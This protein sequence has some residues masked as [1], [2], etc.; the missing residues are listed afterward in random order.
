MTFF[1]SVV[2]TA[3]TTGAINA[4]Y[5]LTM[6]TSPSPIA[7]SLLIAWV[8]GASI[9]ADTMTGWTKVGTAANSNS[10]IIVWAKKSAGGGSDSGTVSGSFTGRLAQVKEVTGWDGVIANIGIATA[11][12]NVVD[13][14]NLNMTTARD[15]LWLAFARNDSASIT[16]APTNYSGLTTAVFSASNL[17]V[18]SRALNA[19]AEDPG[20]FTTGALSLAVAGVIAIRPAFA[21]SS[22][23]MPFFL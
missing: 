18:A 16:A 9:T 2:N 21:P 4:S 11:T 8:A 13:P 14:P 3:N 23:F 20:A 19:S 5:G 17:A 6:P 22:S 7:E 10:D 1:P 15:Y 12:T